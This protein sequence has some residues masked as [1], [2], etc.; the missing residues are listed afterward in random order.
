ML[1]RFVPSGVQSNATKMCGL[2]PCGRIYICYS[3]CGLLET[4]TLKIRTPLLYFFSFPF[5]FFFACVTSGAKRDSAPYIRPL[6]LGGHIDGRVQVRCPLTNEEKL[7]TSACYPPHLPTLAQFV[8]D[9]CF[10]FSVTGADKR[11]ISEF[12]F[13]LCVPLNLAACP[14]QCT[15]VRVSASLNVPKI[16]LA[17][18]AASY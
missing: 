3:I 2:K 5:F 17:F 11:A 13:K 7:K 1:G 12:E 10:F 18:Y 14:L 16:S 9:F 8:W 6:P 4:M 15:Y